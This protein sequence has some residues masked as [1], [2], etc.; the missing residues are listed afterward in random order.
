ME[1]GTGQ[2]TPR[3]VSR[4]ESEGIG[5][6]RAKD[7]RKPQKRRR[8]SSGEDVKDEGR[9]LHHLCWAD[10]LYAMAGTMNH[11]TPYSGRHD[12]RCCTF[13]HEME[14]EVLPLLLDRSRSTNLEMLLRSSATVVDAGPGE[15]WRAWRHWARGWTIEV[16]RRPVCGTES[17]KPT[18]RSTR[19]KLCSAIPN[20]RSKGVLTPSTRR[21]YQLRSMVLVN[22]PTHSQC[23]RHCAFWELGEASSCPVPSQ[24]TK[25]AL[26]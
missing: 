22:G 10:D 2:C 23:S 13:G 25:R 19:R 15:W 8:G 24:E 1:S 6:M 4:W 12:Q 9:V 21:V 26:G 18:P 20:C 14:R 7:N 16:A 17:P 5:F 3:T 11:L